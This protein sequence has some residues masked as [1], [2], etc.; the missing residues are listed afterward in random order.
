MDRSKQK[1]REKIKQNGKVM[2]N[3]MDYIKQDIQNLDR[4]TK[5]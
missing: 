4:I 3:N 5:I 1:I 2:D